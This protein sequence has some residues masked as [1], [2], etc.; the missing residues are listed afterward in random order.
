MDMR[1]LKLIN[2]REVT[3]Q[4]NKQPLGLTIWFREQ[5]TTYDDLFKRPDKDSELIQGLLNR[6]FVLLK[7]VGK[8]NNWDRKQKLLDEDWSNLKS[9]IDAL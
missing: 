1:L 9:E 6:L 4:L 5:M 2:D 7:F 8:P 3:C